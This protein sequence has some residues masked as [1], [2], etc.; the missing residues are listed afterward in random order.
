MADKYQGT[1]DTI[2]GPSRKCF[3]ITPSDT[4]A[5]PDV[6]KG[7]YVG[8]GGNIT[9]RLVDDTTDH[10]WKNLGSGFLPLRFAFIRSTGTTAADLIAHL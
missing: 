4:V 3:D 7:I 10:V 1:A 5:L 6:P 9:G 8:T 2:I